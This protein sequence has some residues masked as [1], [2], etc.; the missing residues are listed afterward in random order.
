MFL[1]ATAFAFQFGFLN[2]IFCCLHQYRMP[3]S[4]RNRKLAARLNGDFQGY[5]PSN[6]CDPRHL[7]VGWLGKENPCK[8]GFLLDSR[9]YREVNQQDGISHGSN[10]P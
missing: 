9:R 7:R 1:I 8:C 3:H 5:W 4:F 10:S 2:A 6:M